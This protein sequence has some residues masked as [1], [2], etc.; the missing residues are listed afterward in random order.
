MFLRICR[1]RAQHEYIP[2]FSVSCLL[3]LTHRWV[4]ISVGRYDVSTQPVDNNNGTCEWYQSLRLK[5][6]FALPCD[7]AQVPDLIIHL[8]S[9]S[10]RMSFV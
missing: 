9:V 1:F 2:P 3:F 5:S 6:N 10:H 7:P 4:K 8:M